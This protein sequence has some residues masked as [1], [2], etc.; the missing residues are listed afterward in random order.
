MIK[1]SMVTLSQ[2]F[3]AASPKHPLIHI[4]ILVTLGRIMDVASIGLQNVAWVSG[5]EAMRQS[6]KIFMRSQGIRINVYPKG[7]S[8][9]SYG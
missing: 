3:M 6:M 9:G 7:T 8:I 2:Y 5:P 4:S 1:W